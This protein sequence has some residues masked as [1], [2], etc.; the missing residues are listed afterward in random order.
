ATFCARGAR[1]TFLDRLLVFFVL[2]PGRGFFLRSVLVIVIAGAL[3][4]ALLLFERGG[5]CLILFLGR[6]SHGALA[7]GAGLRGAVFGLLGVTA[8]RALDGDRHG[9][10]P[11]EWPGAKQNARSQR[12]CNG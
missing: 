4:G 11:G 1:L 8:V 7:L 10:I 3:L 9:Q 2:V 12:K 5:L 6:G